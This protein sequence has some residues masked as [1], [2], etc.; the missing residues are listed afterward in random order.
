MKKIIS[1]LA[2][3][4]FSL[5]VFAGCTSRNS[6]KVGDI[7]SITYTAT[8]PDGTLFDQ[9]T[10]QT[11]LMFSVGSGNVIQGL[12]EGIIGMKVGG[13][14]TLTIAP[15]KGYGKLYNANNI[16]RISKLIFDKLSIKPENGTTQKLGNIEGII[17]GTE[18]DGSGNA[19][20]LFDINPRQTRDTLK[21]KVTILAKQQ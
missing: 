11:P 19:L 13:T 18:N 9:N 2:I 14:K 20:V 16:Q 3:A 17:K 6:V 4:S 8:F 7:I 5:L 10:V 12:D 15:D 21:Y 1:F